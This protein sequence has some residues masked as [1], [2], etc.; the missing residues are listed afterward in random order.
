MPKN[1]VSIFNSDDAGGHVTPRADVWFENERA[2]W[3]AEFDAV[4]EEAVRHSVERNSYT[5]TG[6]EIARQWLVRREFLQ[7][8][9]DVQSSRTLAEQAQEAAYESLRIASEAFA[10]V[11]RADANSLAM[12]EIAAAAKKRARTMLLVGIAASLFGLS[13]IGM[14]LAS[15][16]QGAATAKQAS[17]QLFPAKQAVM[18]PLPPA[19]PPEEPRQVSE[20]PP[21]NAQKVPSNAPQISLRDVK[22]EG[23]SLAETRQAQAIPLE[24]VQRG[25]PSSVPPAIPP[26]PKRE[27]RPLAE[28]L[29]LIADQVVGEGTLNFTMQFQDM[30]TGLDH[31]E[32]LSYKA[33]NVTID[34]NRCQVGYQ[35][36][37]EKDGRTLSDQDRTIELP[38]AKSV[39]VTSID[40]EPGRRYLVRTDPKVYVV[41]IARWDN[42]SGDN[43]Y[44]HDKDVAARVGS[45]TRQALELCGNGEQQLRGR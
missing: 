19:V 27:G 12:A 22:T 18:R 11:S 10:L 41:H 3:W 1:S 25:Q 33:S 15:S 37:V 43:L 45:A 7:L 44:F 2:M 32:Q 16:R 39:W 17:A 21:A 42:A 24:S 8:R 35:W 14:M 29:A 31:A 4:G 23:R 20:I 40:D 13:A 26:A 34:P 9:G 30:A 6:M 36:H 28:A 38:L 5:P